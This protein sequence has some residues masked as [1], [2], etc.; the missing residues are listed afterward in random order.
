MQTYI[1]RRFACNRDAFGL[2][3]S[4]VTPWPPFRVTVNSS[5]K[6]AVWEWIGGGVV[7]EAILQDMDERFPAAEIWKPR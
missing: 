7:S 6:K 5:H 1:V 2:R 4:P 3:V